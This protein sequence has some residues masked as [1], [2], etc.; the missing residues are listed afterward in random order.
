MNGKPKQSNR[1]ARSRSS[2]RRPHVSQRESAY[3]IK[4]ILIPVDFSDSSKES[5]GHAI[6]LAQQF[7]ARLIPVHVLEPV[8]YPS[9]MAFAP[10]AP[11]FPAGISVSSVRKKLKEW[12][13]DAIPP[14]MLGKPE[15]RVGQAYYEIAEAAKEMKADMIV[16]STHGYTGL[17][18]VLLGSTAERIVRH[19]PCPVLTV[20]QKP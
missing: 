2:R 8:I 4:R 9:D 18:H 17:K 6:A 10:L 7:R 20:R 16:I 19:A 15:I 12:C 3:R 14:R 5:L 13:E 1:S 11:E